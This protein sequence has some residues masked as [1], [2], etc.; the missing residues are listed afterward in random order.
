LS[1]IVFRNIPKETTP[2]ELADY[3]WLTVG[4]DVTEEAIRIITFG[5]FSATAFITISDAAMVEFMKRN[6]A[7][8]PFLEREVTVELVKTQPQR[9]QQRK[10]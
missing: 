5:T 1:N 3:L 4:L 2:T 8:K 10:G 6:L 9:G 7:D